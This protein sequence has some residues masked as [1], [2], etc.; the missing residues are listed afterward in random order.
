M[1]IEKAE[2][3]ST[4]VPKRWSE[5][6]A[7][8]KWGR[9]ATVVVLILLYSALA[10]IYSNDYLDDPWIAYR[11]AR[12]L[13][14]GDGLVWNVGER[15]V[16]GYT[17]FLWVI[18]NSL[19]IR[20]SIFPL[21][22]SKIISLFSGIVMIVAV[23]S[24]LNKTVTSLYPT[25]YISSTHQPLPRLTIL[26]P[27][28]NGDSFLYSFCLLGN[29]CLEQQPRTSASQRL[30]FPCLRDVR[31]CFSNKTRGTIALYHS[32]ILRSCLYSQTH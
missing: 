30:P 25:P 12:N 16:E 3:P 15:P 9:V 6:V 17:C 13:A 21:P 22:G 5:D 27:K 31:L 29:Y 7:L 8:Q 1:A 2:E 32:A 4:R 28:W 23:F 19:F 14:R 18:M 10:L 26:R 11:Y 20:L 24:P